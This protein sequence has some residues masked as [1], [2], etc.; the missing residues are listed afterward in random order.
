MRIG[1]GSDLDGF[2]FKER[3][4]AR[5]DARSHTIQDVCTPDLDP[6]GYHEVTD[7]LASAIRTGQVDRGMLICSSSIGAAVAANKYSRV[8]AA[9][10]H[11]PYCAQRGVQDENM[12][13]LVMDA[14][15]VTHDLACA[16]ADA[17]TKASYVRPPSACGIHPRFLARVVDYIRN[18]IDAPLVVSELASLAEMS[19]SHFS[20]LFKRD[21][22]LTPHQFILHER[23]NCSKDLL[24]HGL[25]IVDTAL[26]VGFQNQAHFTTAFGSLVGLT[27]RRFQLL[28][29]DRSV[30][31]IMARDAGINPSIRTQQSLDESGW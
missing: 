6:S 8:R 13:L 31:E 9:V 2:E 21:T 7:R 17:F 22:G 28:S 4:K 24:R 20:K 18:H 25:R 12:N 23:I 3:L 14:R 19:E 30:R 1:I 15:V 26:E 16:L 5:F 10:C 29:C 11:E 27:P